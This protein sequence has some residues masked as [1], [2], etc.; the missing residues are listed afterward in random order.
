MSEESRDYASYLLRLWRV[1]Q[2][3]QIDAAEW[4]GALNFRAST[5]W[6]ASLESTQTGER[7]NFGSLEE[8]LAFLRSGFGAQIDIMSGSGGDK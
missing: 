8:L 5:A 2:A 4:T 1:D 3:P 6:R 7:K